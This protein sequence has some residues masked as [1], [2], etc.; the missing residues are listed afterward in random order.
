MHVSDRCI[1]MYI[2]L[3]KHVTV[4]GLFLLLLYQSVTCTGETDVLQLTLESWK[5]HI[6]CMNLSDTENMEDMT[7]VCRH[8]FMHSS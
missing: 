4:K 2:I 3:M 5:N 8:A 1:Y 6:F 7:A